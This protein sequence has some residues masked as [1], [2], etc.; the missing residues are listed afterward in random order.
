[1][2]RPSRHRDNSCRGAKKAA[3]GDLRKPADDLGSGRSKSPSRSKSPAVKS[4]SKRSKSPSRRKQHKY[5]STGMDENT[6][7]EIVFDECVGGNGSQPPKSVYFGGCCWGAAF[8]VG[9]Y[10]AMVE[11]WGDDFRHKTLITGDSAGSIFALG[12]ALGRTPEQMDTL[13]R[14]MSAKSHSDGVIGK[15]SIWIEEYL[16]ELFRTLP[17]DTHKKLEGKLRFG[18]TL[19]PFEHQWHES[20]DSNEHLLSELRLSYHVP[21]YCSRSKTIQNGVHVVDGAYGF[22]GHDLPHHD[23]TLFVGIDP[24]AEITRHFTLLEMFWPAVGEKYDAIV[25]SGY[26]EMMKWDGKHKVKLGSRVANR[27][28]LYVL[29]FLKI[30][31]IIADLFE[32][33]V[34]Q[35]LFDVVQLLTVGTTTAV[36]DMSST[37]ASTAR[38]AGVEKATTESV[39]IVSTTAR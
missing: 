3:G 20:W 5:T 15:C 8:Y 10:K 37:V 33:I 16:L 35:L 36:D 11:K 9:V 21:I 26:Q 7:I 23:E 4:K 24:H 2:K 6:G 14:N 18:T 29:W 1:M 12:I 22:A 13:Y 31:E 17:E 34:Y 19:F 39:M 25:D 27:P 38:V 30:F 28:A 32:Y